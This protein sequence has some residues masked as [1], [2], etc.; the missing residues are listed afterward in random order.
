MAKLR[1][2]EV[3]A[4]RR[5][6]GTASWVAGLNALALGLAGSVLAM[7]TPIG[8]AQD[9]VRM[10]EANGFEVILNTVD[11]PSLDQCTVTAVRPGPVVAESVTTGRDDPREKPSYTTVYVDVKC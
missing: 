1:R 8:S 11:T 10:L 2:L 7:P 4:M 3:A 9:I 6:A 5:F